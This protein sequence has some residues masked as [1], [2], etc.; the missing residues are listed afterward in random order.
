M[1][2]ILSD[3]NECKESS[4]VIMYQIDINDII[5]N[6][7]GISSLLG[8][9]G[10]LIFTDNRAVLCYDKYPCLRIY[11]KANHKLEK[12]DFKFLKNSINIIGKGEKETGNWRKFLVDDIKN[13]K[14]ILI[15]VSILYLMV[16]NFMIQPLDSLV[17]FNDNLINVISIFMGM[18]F[19]F[20]GFFYG[21]RKKSI[22]EFKKGNADYQYRVDRYII[23]LSINAIVFLLLSN[24]IGRIDD[25]TYLKNILPE[26]LS[27][28]LSRNSQFIIC[29]IFSWLAGEILVICF[30]T[31]MEYY[32]LDMR[33]KYFIDAVDDLVKERRESIKK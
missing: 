1:N 3:L 15:S 5:D 13:N 31:L 25:V 22:D 27:I 12:S 4:S 33:N 6:Y 2:R 18:F 32:F 19:V 21:D 28:L 16:F 30:K 14:W 7:T 29:A 24:G 8:E 26:N 10:F 20:V 11:I 23:I 9:H 17:S